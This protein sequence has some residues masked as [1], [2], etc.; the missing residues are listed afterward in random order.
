MANEYESDAR[1]FAAQ[2]ELVILNL[3]SFMS[4]RSITDIATG[5]KMLVDH[6]NFLTPRFTTNIQSNIN[7]IFFFAMQ[8]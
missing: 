3:E 1:R 4:N 8:Y 5:L 7:K 2:L 6:I